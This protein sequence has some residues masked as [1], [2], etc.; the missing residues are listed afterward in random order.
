[1]LNQVIITSGTT[2]PD[3]KTLNIDSVDP[4]ELVIVK[5]I[6]GLTPG[7]IQLFTGEFARAGGYYQG[8]R[9]GKRNPVFNLKL[10]PDY[11]NDI[12]VS[13]VRQMIYDIFLEKGLTN[14]GDGIQV[15]LKDDKA[16]DKTFIGYC[17][18]LDPDM[19][20]KTTDA[21]VSLVCTEAY[22]MATE[23][24]SVHSPSGLVDFAIQY[25]GG[26]KVGIAVELRVKA[27]TNTL[28][29]NRTG[30]ASQYMQL[31][32]PFAVN[33]LV[34]I[35]TVEGQRYIRVNGVDVMASLAPGSSWLQLRK[36]QNNF[37]VFG[38]S[39]GDGRVVLERYNYRAA[40]WGI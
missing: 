24:T 6:S 14:G 1:M 23:V 5:S 10:N 9:P 38:S 32:R 20:L 3:P 33:D 13:E 19:F 30:A 17:E 8:R 18:K 26:A 15:I 16:V 35:N 40:W 27:I 39:P 11:E 34:T 25:D 7:D 21:Q 22:L 31:N 12:D 2:D 28:T 29:I 37:S 36:G 4:N